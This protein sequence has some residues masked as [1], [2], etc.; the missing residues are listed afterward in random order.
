MWR[1]VQKSDDTANPAELQTVQKMWEAININ[2]ASSI[3]M[4]K[5][6]RL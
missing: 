3:Y 5:N 2:N 6:K 1:S 4:R